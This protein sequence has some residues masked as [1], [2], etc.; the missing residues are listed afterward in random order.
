MKIKMKK[1]QAMIEY[2]LVFTVIFVCVV[3]ALQ[4]FIRAVDKK[5]DDSRTMVT[6]QDP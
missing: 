6:A 2:I 4:Y 5:A 3:V 1:A